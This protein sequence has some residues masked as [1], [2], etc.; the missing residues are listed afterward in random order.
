LVDSHEA[1]GVEVEPLGLK[2][3][4]LFEAFARLDKTQ[5]IA[6]A[7]A[8]L[9]ETL[10]KNPGAVPFTA[11]EVEREKVKQKNDYD[12]IL[13][14][15]AELVASLAEA[16]SLG[17]WRLFYI[18][19]DRI[20]AVTP[21]DVERVALAYLK[22][23]NRTLGIFEPTPK[24][25]LAVIPE[26]PDVAKLVA[27]YEGKAAQE[28]VA[29]FDTAPEAIE[30]RVERSRLANGMQIALLNKETRG[31]AVSGT[32]ILRMGDAK[33]LF[34]QKTIAQLT[35]A[36]LLRGTTHL[37]RQEIADRLDQLDAKLSISS[38]GSAVIVQFQTRRDK[39]R[40]RARDQFEPHRAPVDRSPGLSAL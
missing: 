30:K 39:L 31:A 26:A 33:S 22:P 4:G 38:Q 25:D 17:D 13:D 28:S 34:G 6:P 2:E 7:E 1:A 36:M 15:P 19:R 29:A 3:P 11:E 8:T 35:A 20:A 37:S 5:T 14:E 32:I 18:E 23:S 24:P 16:D 10:E 21:A 40:E 12:K 9:L 27:N